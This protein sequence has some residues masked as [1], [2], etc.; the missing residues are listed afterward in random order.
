MKKYPIIAAILLSLAAVAFKAVNGIDGKWTGTLTGSD[1]NQPLNYTF[2]NTNGVLTGFT[3]NPSN[4]QYDISDGKVKGDSIS[5]SIV[6]DNGDKIIN[7]GRYYPVGDS[8]SLKVVFMG[9]DMHA[10]LK[11]ASDK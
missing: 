9:A 11:R 4:V 3:L 6:V 1:F 5:F 7:T 10:S 2:K 8:I